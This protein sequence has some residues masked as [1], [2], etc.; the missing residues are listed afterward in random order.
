[1]LSEAADDG[2]AVASA[3]MST[4]SSE[5]H[6]PPP[7]PDWDT[8]GAHGSKD[9]GTGWAPA[10]TS[11]LARWQLATLAVAGAG[12]CLYV[13]LV[14]PNTSS[15]YPQCPM[16]AVTGLDCAGCGGLRAT[17]ALLT[18][19][20]TRAVDHNL[21]VVLLAPLAVYGIVQVLL[22][23]R[24]RRLPRIRYRG[25][26]TP[27]ILVLLFGFSVARNFEWGPFPYLHSDA[28]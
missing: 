14:D 1:M 19:D 23:Q 12:A 3:T 21:L 15:A 27:V 8:A 9:G 20:F 13:A 10:T 11:V 18:G 17:N 7:P 16:R 26:M 28:G 25:W 6:R 5:A 24:G 2:W 4:G 22:A